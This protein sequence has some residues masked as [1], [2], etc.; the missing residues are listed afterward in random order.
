MI[1]SSKIRYIFRNKPFKNFLERQMSKDKPPA[2]LTIKIRNF[3]L[4]CC[5]DLPSFFHMVIFSTSVITNHFI[6]SSVTVF[7]KNYVNGI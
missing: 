2:L 5:D 3:V 6:R 1:N 4:Y 7:K